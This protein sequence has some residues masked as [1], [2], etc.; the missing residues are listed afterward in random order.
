[1][2][3]VVL[4]LPLSEESCKL[5]TF[6]TSFGH[7]F[8]QS[9]NIKFGVCNAPRAFPAWHM[10]AIFFGQDSA[11][12]HMDDV[13][14]FGKDQEEHNTHLHAALTKIRSAGVTLNPDKCEF[15]KRS[16]IF[17]GHVINQ[18]G[19]FADP[20]KTKAVV[21]VSHALTNVTELRRFLGMHG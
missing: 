16:I 21:D 17:L 3:I 7:N 12:C 5:T 14:I 4:A 18:E 19:V 1:M 15:A 9:V 8:F 20:D 11:L 6:V 10:S 2:P 13:F